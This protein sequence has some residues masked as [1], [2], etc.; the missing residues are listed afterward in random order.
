MLR[1][2]CVRSVA[3]RRECV[4]TLHSRRF[5]FP[6]HMRAIATSACERLRHA[7]ALV[8]THASSSSWWRAQNRAHRRSDTTQ[9]TTQ[10]PH[11][12]THARRVLLIFTGIT[13]GPGNSSAY[14]RPGGGICACDRCD[15][16]NATIAR[17]LW[18]NM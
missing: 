18:G 3:S 9:N 11:A 14:T 4:R 13:I 12:Q 17:D 16:A 8:T 15:R 2:A 5:V 6:H 10:T 7:P 1:R